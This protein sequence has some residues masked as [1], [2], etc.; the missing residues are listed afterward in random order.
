MLLICPAIHQPALH[1]HINSDISSSSL[2]VD[3]QA[4]DET[5]ESTA[6]T[7]QLLRHFASR[8]TED[9]VLVPC[10]FI[11]PPS[12]PLSLLLNK[13]RI[14]STSHNAIVSTCWYP[15]FIPE[16]GQLYEEWGPVPPPPAIVWD[17]ST[18][19]LLHVD[20]PDDHD[21]NADEIEFKMDLLSRHPRSKLSASFQDS[22]V[23]VCQRSV[24]LLLQDKPRFESFR[25]DF[26]PWLCKLQYQ[27]TKR[28][29]FAKGIYLVSSM[30][31]LLT[32]CSYR[33]RSGKSRRPNPRTQTFDPQSRRSKF[34]SSQPHRHRGGRRN[35]QATDVQS[36]HLHSLPCRRTRSPHQQPL[37]LP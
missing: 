9:F 37:R 21:K 7:A 26:I 17:P 6:G 3:I 23:Y 31:F 29:K 19:S 36:L 10:D 15:A 18:D 27:P 5:Q 30:T 35:P 13:F 22:H 1:H 34:E 16:K 28:R 24:L 20:T 11:A 32:L 2:S 33:V 14:E 12:L 4:Y 25:Q 8:I